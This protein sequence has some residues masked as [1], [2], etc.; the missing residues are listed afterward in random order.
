MRLHPTASH[1]ILPTRT[2]PTC[3]NDQEHLEKA[4]SL[5]L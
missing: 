5:L 2:I 4:I 1:Y 3:S